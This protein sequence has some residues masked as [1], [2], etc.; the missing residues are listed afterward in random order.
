MD[1]NSNL[2]VETINVD[3]IKVKASNGEIVEVDV[4]NGK[5]IK[6]DIA[7]GIELINTSTVD[8][9]VENENTVIEEIEV[10]LENV[11]ETKIETDSDKE[12]KIVDIEIDNKLFID[13]SSIDI[14]LDNTKEADIDINNEDK[15]DIEFN[16]GDLTETADIDINVENEAKVIDYVKEAST[17]T[18]VYKIPMPVIPF[19]E[20]E[21]IKEVVPVVIEE[22]IVVAKEDKKTAVET[23][24]VEKSLVDKTAFSMNAG[25]DKQGD[26]FVGVGIDTELSE[27]FDSSFEFGFLKNDFKAGEEDLYFRQEIIYKDMFI[28]GI[29]LDGNQNLSAEVGVMGVFGDFTGKLKVGHGIVKSK[30]LEK[31]QTAQLEYKLDETASLFTRFEGRKFD[32]GEKREN[33]FFG[34]KFNF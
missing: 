4:E 19:F 7:N 9:E 14:E 25:I 30:R 33:T 31:T 8:L 17:L 10:E 28:G 34:I 13:K 5:T 1:N 21:P 3:D 29:K 2:R 11:Y 24:D 18:P 32:N 23:E 26:L 20:P 27:D 22:P 15:T 16:N 6:L 12:T